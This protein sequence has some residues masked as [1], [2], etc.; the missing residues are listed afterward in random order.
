MSKPIDDSH[1][2]FWLVGLFEGEACFL[3]D[4]G[5]RNPEIQLEM[6]DEH[7]IARVAALFGLGYQRRDRRDRQPN[8][9][10][11]YRVRIYG[12]R[13]LQVMKRIEPYMSPRRQSAILLV[14]A[15][16][17]A[18]RDGKPSQYD[19]FPLPPLTEV[20]YRLKYEKSEE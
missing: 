6:V 10:V 3:Y 2:F 7:V 13:A 17:R 15:K 1:T 20:P 18:D 9:N 14:E 19:R 4:R 12:R 11:S 8:S 16:Y 5:K